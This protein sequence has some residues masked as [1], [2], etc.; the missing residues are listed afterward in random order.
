M[1]PKDSLMDGGFQNYHQLY[2][3]IS[4]EVCEKQDFC[5]AS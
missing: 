4:K 5:V 3:Y 2:R 1:A